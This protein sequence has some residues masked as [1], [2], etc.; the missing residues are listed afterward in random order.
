MRHGLPELTIKRP[1]LERERSPRFR[2]IMVYITTGHNDVY[3]LPTVALVRWI[4]PD[5]RRHTLQCACTALENFKAYHD[6]ESSCCVVLV[7][8]N[9]AMGVVTD[10]FDTHFAL[11]GDWI[12]DEDLRLFKT[13]LRH[14]CQPRPNPLHLHPVHP[15]AAAQGLCSAGQPAP[16]YAP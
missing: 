1:T 3:L 9:V 5:N 11:L 10:H 7:W 15:P 12:A 6:I 16:M 4:D 8:T 13:F 2:S 14:C